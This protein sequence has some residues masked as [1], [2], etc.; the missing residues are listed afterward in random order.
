[1]LRSL[2]PELIHASEE[3]W[4]ASVPPENK[5]LLAAFPSPHLSPSQHSNVSSDPVPVVTQTA[6]HANTDAVYHSWCWMPW[7]AFTLARQHAYTCARGTLI[8]RQNQG[9]GSGSAPRDTEPLSLIDGGWSHALN[10]SGAT[11]VSGR[12]MSPISSNVLGLKHHSDDKTINL[13]HG[14]LASGT[15]KLPNHRGI[16][17]H[18]YTHQSFSLSCS[19]SLPHSHSSTKSTFQKTSASVS[20]RSPM[21]AGRADGD[22]CAILSKPH[23]QG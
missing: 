7:L 21:F 22:V 8:N 11:D 4:R 18:L 3:L 20:L 19:A 6:S 14:S 5:R 12:E 13:G 17:L 15:Q 16:Y 10:N 1:M 23:A 2:G 9:T